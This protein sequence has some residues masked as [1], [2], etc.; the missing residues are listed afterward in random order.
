[1]LNKPMQLSMNEVTK[2]SSKDPCVHDLIV[3]TPKVTL[4]HTWNSLKSVPMESSFPPRKPHSCFAVYS[5]ADLSKPPSSSNT[6]F[7]VSEERKPIV[8]HAWSPVNVAKQT[9]VSTCLANQGYV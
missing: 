9:K 4:P 5:N 1:M 2:H 8:L 6:S 3:P 7:M